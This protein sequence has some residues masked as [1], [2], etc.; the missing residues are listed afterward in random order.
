MTDERN[1]T[2]ENDQFDSWR[3]PE[4]FSMPG[5]GLFDE[6]ADLTEEY[7]AP[8]SEPAAETAAAQHLKRPMHSAEEKPPM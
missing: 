6:E 1:E 8:V 2:P 4:D 3:R 5:A 7:Q